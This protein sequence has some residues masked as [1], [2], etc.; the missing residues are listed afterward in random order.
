MYLSKAQD[1]SYIEIKSDVVSDFILN[2]T[3]YT[4]LKIQGTLNC[5]T[6]ETEEQTISGD[7]IGTNLFTLQF[8]TNS[9]AVI[10]E[11]VFKN[12]YTQQEWNALSADENVS[13]YM[14]NVGDITSLYPVIQA[15]FTANFAT[16]VTQ[17]YTYNSGTNTCEYTITDLPT[18]VIPLKM[19]IEVN[20]TLQEIYFGYSP[21]VGIYSTGTSFYVSPSFFELLTFPNGIYSFVLTFTT[22]AGDIITIN[23]CFFFDC[24]TKCVVSQKIEEL[25]NCNKTATNIFLLHYTLTEGSNC[26]CNCDELCVIFNKLCSE[27]NLSESCSNCGC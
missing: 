6:A 24:E 25:L 20:G 23:N 26:G 14:C 17:G 12:I 9:A 22:E 4:S 18:N 1:C 10:K 27:L 2:P 19:I 11:I 16:T 5:C 15:W 13:D 7:Q 21:F 8:P 3:N